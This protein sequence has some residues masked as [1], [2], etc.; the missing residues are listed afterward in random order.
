MDHG[1]TFCWIL[2]VNVLYEKYTEYIDS[3]LV[4]TQS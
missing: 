2:L 3:F 1:L 4:K